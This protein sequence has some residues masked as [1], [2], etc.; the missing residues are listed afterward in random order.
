MLTKKT[1]PGTLVFRVGLQINPFGGTN[2]PEFFFVSKHKSDKKNS[3][4]FLMFN[5]K[6]SQSIMEN[7]IYFYCR[8]AFT[9]KESYTFKWNT[10]FFSALVPAYKNIALFAFWERKRKFRI[11]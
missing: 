2:V 4:E 7:K 9:I 5:S 3:H 6:N 1:N 8:C 11:I 10:S